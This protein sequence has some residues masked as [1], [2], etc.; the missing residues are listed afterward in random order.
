MEL[1]ETIK[2]ME[3]DDFK[4]RFKAEYYQLKIRRNKLNEMLQNY[5]D[6]KLNFEPNTPI[7]LFISQLALMDG[8]MNI[9][10]ARAFI[11]DIEL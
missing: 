5:A 2:L 8:Y 7:P 4:E 3:S 1:K 10:K 11:E 9:L 6:G